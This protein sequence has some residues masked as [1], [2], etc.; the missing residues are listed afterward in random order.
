MRVL[1]GDGK[2]GSIP[3]PTTDGQWPLPCVHG[4]MPMRAFRT[5]LS[6]FLLLCLCFNGSA[7]ADEEKAEQEFVPYMES[8][9][10]HCARYSVPESL[11]LAIARQESGFQPWAVNIQGKSYFPSSREGLPLLSLRQKEK[12]TAMT[13]V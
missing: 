13:L 10:T 8:F 12:G 11:A 9:R 5:L 1:K 4:G 6:S 7:I 2:A 3:M